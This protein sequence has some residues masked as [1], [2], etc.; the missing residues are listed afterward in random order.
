MKNG[1]AV[2][3]YDISI[4]TWNPSGSVDVLI[5]GVLSSSHTIKFSERT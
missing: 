3:P 4:E 1:K 2:V 5:I